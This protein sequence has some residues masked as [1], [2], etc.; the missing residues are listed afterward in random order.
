MLH[1]IDTRDWDAVRA[2]FADTVT[3]DYTSLF[4]GEVET[5]PAD[6]LVDGWARFVPGFDATQHLAGPVV[7]EH[8]GAT[9]HAHCAITATHCLGE[10]RWIVGGHYALQLT[11][12]AT[13]W[14]ITHLTLETA[15]QD[16]D[17]SL[18][19]QAAERD[20]RTEPSP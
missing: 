3:T 11:T 4:G 20:P 14:R 6:D 5:Q 17:R 9:A 13:G 8:D 12:S 1:A 2:A 18:P 10:A 16:G 19:Q 7:A 15:F